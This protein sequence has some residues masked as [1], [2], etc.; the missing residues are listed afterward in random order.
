MAS[1][2]KSKASETKAPAKSRE[3]RQL[4]KQ[5]LAMWAL[6]GSGGAGFGGALTSNLIAGRLSA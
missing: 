4:E 6:L 5:A 1:R 3:Q 2:S